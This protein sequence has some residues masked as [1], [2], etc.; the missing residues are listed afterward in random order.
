DQRIV[1]F[2]EVDARPARPL[3]GPRAD[4][5]EPATQA[6]DERVSAVAPPHEAANDQDHL[7][8]LVHGALVERIDRMTATNELGRDVGLQIGERQNQ[9]GLQRLDGFEARVKKAG[10]PRLLTGLRRSHGVAGDAYDTVAL[11]EEV[12]RLGGLLGQA[13]DAARVTVSQKASG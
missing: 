13:D 10:D 9:V 5:V 6:L 3:R 2:L 11:A 4:R 8:D 7:E 12:E 1:P